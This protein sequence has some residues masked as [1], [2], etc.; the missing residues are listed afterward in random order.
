[1]VIPYLIPS[2]VWY[3][4]GC[5]LCFKNYQG[6]LYCMTQ[7]LLKSCIFSY[8]FPSHTFSPFFTPSPIPL[9]RHL[10][11]TK[12]SLSFSQNAYTATAINSTNFCTSAKDA[13]VI[14]VENALRVAAINTVG[15][16]MLFLGKVCLGKLCL[17]MTCTSD[18]KCLQI[19]FSQLSLYC[20]QLHHV[21]K[22]LSKIRIS[23][24]VRQVSR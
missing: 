20:I 11:S 4:Q 3:K 18:T 9:L 2:T 12:S 23:R 16:F 6:Y 22:E 19:S 7:D 13:F 5:M 14:L 1:M 21:Q 24:Q 8:S 15:D 10:S 17:A